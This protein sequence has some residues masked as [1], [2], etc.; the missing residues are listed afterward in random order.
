MME[1]SKAMEDSSIEKSSTTYLAKEKRLTF[2][3]MQAPLL[4]KNLTTN[5]KLKS[6]AVSLKFY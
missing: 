3:K 6:L 4:N 5:M 2:V 1:D